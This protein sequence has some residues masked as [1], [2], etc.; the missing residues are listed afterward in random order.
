MRSLSIM[1]KGLRFS[2]S[3]LTEAVLDIQVKPRDELT[4]IALEDIQKGHEA[5]Y[6]T[7]QNRMYFQSEFS[8]D[9]DKPLSIASRSQIGYNF[10][11]VDE[12]QIVQVGLNGFTFNRLVPYESWE[13]FSA[14]ARVWWNIYRNIAKPEAIIRLAVRYINRLDLPLP[15]EDLKDYLKTVPEISGDLSQELSGYFMQLRLP[16][17][18]I[19]G[20]LILSEALIAPVKP[21]AISVVLDIDLFR[22]SKIP[23]N[24]EAIWEY[25]EQLRIKKNI[26]FL[27]CITERTKELI[28]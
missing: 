17:D 25:F 4:L 28:S 27:A 2:K 24:E 1:G 10:V 6:P 7:R 21:N 13:T 14:E 18:D 15:V 20:N 12:R 22:D 3:P 8:I 16:Q 23:N 19:E 5:E 9:P 11:S 26:I